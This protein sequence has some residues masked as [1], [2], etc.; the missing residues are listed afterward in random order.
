MIYPYNFMTVLPLVIAP[1]L[2]LKQPSKPV[3]EVDESVR[4][5]MDDM[6]E[7]MYAS[8]GIGLAAVQV[9]VHKRV[10]VMDIEQREGERSPLY[11]ANPEI[12]DSSEEYAV[13]NEG[14]LSF[15]GQYSDVERPATLTLRYLD[16][17]N[18]P[19][20]IEADGL[21]ATCIQH[22]IDHIDGIVFVDHVSPMKRDMIMRRLKKAKQK[23]ETA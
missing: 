14:C 1:D 5:L 17:N 23:A 2:R 22:E 7:T 21:L 11:L 16:Y 13:Y 3:A 8:N 10:I 4:K 18:K 6:L 19:Q 9:G 15:P 12:V 20:E